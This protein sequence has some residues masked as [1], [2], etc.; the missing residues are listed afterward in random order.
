M[1]FHPSVLESPEKILGALGKAVQ[2]ITDPV[3]RAAELAVGLAE[4]SE[5]KI[6]TLVT[7]LLDESKLESSSESEA[8]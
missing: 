8:A 4:I 5:G 2:L 7:Q 3:L 6:P 1:T